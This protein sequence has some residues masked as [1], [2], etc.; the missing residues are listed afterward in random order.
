MRTWSIPIGRLFGVDF[1]LHFGFVFLLAFLYF[2]DPQPTAPGVFQHCLA[3]TGIVFGAALLHELGHALA[4][5]RLGVPLR[6]V[7]LLPIGGVPVGDD[8]TMLHGEASE[9]LSDAA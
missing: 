1:R 6:P 5:T 3:L 4:A 2:T 9:P 8:L 7:V